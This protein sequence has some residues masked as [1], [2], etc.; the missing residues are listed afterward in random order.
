MIGKQVSS[1]FYNHLLA[2]VFTP[3][4]SQIYLTMAA[5]NLAKKDQLTFR[6]EI[7]NKFKVFGMILLYFILEN[8]IVAPNTGQ[9]VSF[10]PIMLW[11]II[12]G[13]ISLI[14]NYVGIR[15]IL[16]LCLFLSVTFCYT[17]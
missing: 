11:M 3:W 10:Y 13:F 4:V 9:A 8:F 15:G 14:Y 2:I 6:S 5:F 12:L 1:D 7:G 16:A 17:R